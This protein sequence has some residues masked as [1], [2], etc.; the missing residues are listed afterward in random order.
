MA[1]RRLNSGLRSIYVSIEWQTQHTEAHVKTLRFPVPNGE[2]Y[3]DSE[4][5]RDANRLGETPYLCWIFR[6]LVSDRI[7]LGVS[8]SGVKADFQEGLEIGI[9]AVETRLGPRARVFSL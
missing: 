8:C 7:D 1:D 5:G 3:G 4:S 2:P 9:G 6:I